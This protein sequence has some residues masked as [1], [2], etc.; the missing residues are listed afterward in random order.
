[1]SMF[2]YR[3]PVLPPTINPLLEYPANPPVDNDVAMTE[4]SRFIS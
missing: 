3:F 2:R 1:M 4:H